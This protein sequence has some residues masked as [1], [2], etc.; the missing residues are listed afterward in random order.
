MAILLALDKIHIFS[1]SYL[2][3]SDLIKRPLQEFKN[4]NSYYEFTCFI[5]YVNFRSKYR[6]I[7]VIDPFSSIIKGCVY[8]KQPL[9][10]CLV[11]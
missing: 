3:L 8:L 1:R 2:S 9:H 4:N 7:E 6:S 10:V 11:R 5:I